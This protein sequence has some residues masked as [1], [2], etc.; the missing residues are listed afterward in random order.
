MTMNRLAALFAAGLLLLAL[1]AHARPPL[2]TAAAAGSLIVKPAAGVLWGFSATTGATGGY[3]LLF[4]SATAPADGA[5]TP[6]KCYQLGANSSIGASWSPGPPLTY[7]N[8][9]V[10]VFSTTGC[11]TKTISNTAYFS[12]EYE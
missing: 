10:F 3:L 6:I 5:V 1:P 7:Q 4:D 2:A 9:L 12:V 11:F 8:G